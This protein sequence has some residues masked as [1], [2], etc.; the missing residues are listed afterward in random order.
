MPASGAPTRAILE[1]RG[2]KAVSRLAAL[3]TRA[4]AADPEDALGVRGAARHH[5]ARELDAS[6]RLTRQ[7]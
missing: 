3:S 7:R 4:L 5:I 2:A 1:T 6:T